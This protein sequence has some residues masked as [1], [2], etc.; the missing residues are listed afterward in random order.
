[1]NFSLDNVN[2][3]IMNFEKYNLNKVSNFINKELVDQISSNINKQIKLLKK[4]YIFIDLDKS[5]IK[6]TL[7]SRALSYRVFDNKLKIIFE[8]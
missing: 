3:L 1:M 4:D 8:K 2:F 6:E 5:L 7:L